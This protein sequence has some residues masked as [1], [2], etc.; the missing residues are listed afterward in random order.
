MTEP[1]RQYVTRRVIE[2]QLSD[3]TLDE[4][5]TPDRKLPDCPLCGEDE[6][7]AVGRSGGTRRGFRCYRCSYRFDIEPPP[8]SKPAAPRNVQVIDMAEVQRV[9]VDTELREFAL[10]VLINRMGGVLVLSADEMRH[11]H[12]LPP[13]V[14]TDAHGTVT[15]TATPCPTCNKRRAGVAQA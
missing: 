12:G 11:E 13:T 7:Y 6:L 14:R 9:V 2:Q 4:H 3:I 10:S 1:R 8:S 5:G 15:L